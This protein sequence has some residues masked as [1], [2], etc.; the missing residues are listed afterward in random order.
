MAVRRRRKLRAP[1]RSP[2][3]ARARSADTSRSESSDSRIDPPLERDELVEARVTAAQLL[4]RGPAVIRQ[5]VASAALEGEVDQP[6]K[7]VLRVPPPRRTVHDVQIEDDAGVGR[8]APPGSSRRLFRSAGSSRRSARPRWRGSPPAPSRE[9]G[10]R[11]ARHVDLGDHLGASLAPAQAT[12]Q[13]PVVVVEVDAELLGVG[14]VDLSR[15]GEVVLRVPPEKP[16]SCR[17]ERDT[18]AAASLPATARADSSRHRADGR[19]IERVHALIAG[20]HARAQERVVRGVGRELEIA[21]RAVRRRCARSKASIRPSMRRESR[22]GG[23]QLDTAAEAQ[24]HR[25]RSRRAVRI[26]RSRR[27]T[28][29]RSR[30]GCT[31]ASRR[32]RPPA[33]TTRRSTRWART[34]GRGH[35]C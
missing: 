27:G 18:P 15:R 14:P 4:G 12:V 31:C 23:S 32:R 7:S 13:V 25:V 16:R 33:E 2:R 22:R 1:R 26:R 29:R 6:P 30:C 9:T 10:Q 17:R 34:E 35:E 3:G 5:V 21:E 20:E 11:A 19:R 24:R 28:A 8:R